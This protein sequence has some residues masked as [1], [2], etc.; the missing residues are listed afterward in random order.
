MSNHSDDRVLNNERNFIRKKIDEVK[1][2]IRQ[3]ENNLQFFIN[4]DDDNPL[5]QEVHK[6]IAKHK[7]ELEVWKAK[8]K[9]IKQL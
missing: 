1:G 5:V 9:K 2:E 6:N 3:L 4:T 7:D 8:L